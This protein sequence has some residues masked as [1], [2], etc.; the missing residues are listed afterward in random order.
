EPMARWFE[1]V[2]IAQQ[3]ARRR[4]PPS[5]Y[6]ALLAGAENGVSY[7]DNTHAFTELGFA[8]HVAGQS[9][10][11]DQAT[12]VLGQEISL[13][14]LISP[15]GVQAVHPQGELAVARAAANRGTL[16]G[17]SS[18]A[19]YPME[20]VIKTGARTLVQM[21]WMGSRDFMSWYIDRARAAGAVGLIVTLDWSF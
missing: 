6:S 18:F 2:A 9:A 15:A 10:K 1:T 14:V 16:M 4:L 3:R 21:Y 12:T 19:S 17:L 20:K 13:P 5:V 8:P 11:R 7:R